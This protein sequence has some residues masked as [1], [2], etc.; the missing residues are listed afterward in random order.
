MVFW[1]NFEYKIDD[2]QEEVDSTLDSTKNDLSSLKKSVENQKLWEAEKLP[3]EQIKN[4]SKFYDT[5][6]NDVDW[7]T[8]RASADSV[9]WSTDWAENKKNEAASMANFLKKEK[10]IVVTPDLSTGNTAQARLR[11]MTLVSQLPPSML[12]KIKN[13]IT[14]DVQAVDKTDAK[15]TYRYASLD[16]SI[17]KK[18]VYNIENKQPILDQKEEENI[19]IPEDLE[20]PEDIERNDG[21]WEEIKLPPEQYEKFKSWP[22]L[23]KPLWTHIFLE[24][25]KIPNRN[26]KKIQKNF[27]KR[28]YY[29]LE[30]WKF[31]IK[32]WPWK[33]TGQWFGYYEEKKSNSFV[34]DMSD[35]LW[36][37]Y[38]DDIQKIFKEEKNG[39]VSKAVSFL[40]LFSQNDSMFAI[41]QICNA[42]SKDKGLEAYIMRIQEMQVQ[43]KQHLLASN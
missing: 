19:Q 36:L 27:I 32:N 24:W 35:T 39:R 2:K 25:E 10:W 14:F 3:D 22:V 7:F 11:A 13:K 15:W 42:C 20:N 26:S 37:Q 8:V 5:F 40:N 18:P 38:K 34:V 16:A 1:E 4:I 23:Q 30:D 17:N 33:S 21:G 43:Q 29:K 41:N 12:E 6:G 28:T 9:W 31:M